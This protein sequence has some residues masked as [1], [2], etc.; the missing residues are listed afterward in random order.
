MTG[1]RKTNCIMS[2]LKYNAIKQVMHLLKKLLYFKVATD[3]LIKDLMILWG[4]KI[5]EPLKCMCS[6]MCVSCLYCI[7]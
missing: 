5:F 7:H 3:E 6:Y 2:S 1:L 4:F